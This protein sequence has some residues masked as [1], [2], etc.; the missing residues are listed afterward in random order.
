MK[1]IFTRSIKFSCLGLCGYIGCT[2][3]YLL[4]HLSFKFFVETAFR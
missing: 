3:M 1:A 4:A 2:V